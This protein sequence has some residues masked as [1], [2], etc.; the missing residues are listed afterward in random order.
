MGLLFSRAQLANALHRSPQCLV[1]ILMLACGF[2]VLK[3]SIHG[4]DG[5]Q[6]Y[7][8]LRSLMIDRDLNFSNEFNH[9]YEKEPGWFEF[10]PLLKDPVTGLTTNRYGVGNAILW[11]PFVFAT[12]AGLLAA[13]AARVTVP[14]PDGYSRPYELAVGVGSCFYASV[15]LLLLFIL[16]RRAFREQ[17]AFWAVLLVWLASPLFFYMYL[18]PSMSHAN[19]FF[20]SAVLVWLYFQGDGFGRWCAMGVAY[21]LL[22]MCRFQDAS[23]GAMLAAGEVYRLFHD[24]KD[25]LVWRQAGR[26]VPRYLAFVLCALVAFVPQLC[27]WKY[28]NGSYFTGLRTYRLVGGEVNPLEPVHALEAL[29][30]SRHGLFYWHPGLLIGL[31]GLLLFGRVTLQRIASL[32]A[33]AAQVYV[34]A[35]WSVWWGGASFG[36]R[37]FISTL[38]MLAWGAGTVLMSGRSR[39]VLVPVILFLVFWNFGYVVQYGSGIISRQ[40]GVPLTTL[41]YNNLVRVPKILLHLQ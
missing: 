33:F 4:N 17:A 41:I 13:R 34:V 30:S 11:S 6:N 27:A 39:R 16:L 21:G 22:I 26:R 9:Y 32:G 14:E 5:T 23:L 36:Q 10:A 2:A 25:Q 20:L 35:C 19:S 8:F 38:P 1:L 7:M 15:G 29:F 12:H 40:D 24:R 18:H 31:A 28:L 37:M 3:P